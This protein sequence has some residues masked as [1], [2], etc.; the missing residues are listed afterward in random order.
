MAAQLSDLR[1]QSQQVTKRDKPRTIFELLDDPRVKQGLA[2]VAGRLLSPDRVMKL[3]TNAIYR[4]PKLALCE[5]KTVL[6]CLMASVSLGLEPNTPQGHAYLIPY[7]RRAQISG[8][9]QDVY[10][11]QFQV[12]YRGLI[13]LGYRSSKIRTIEAEAIHA[14]DH[15]KHMKGSKNFLE[16]EIALV[17]R[18]DLV[19]AYCHSHLTDDMEMATVMPLDRILSVRDRSET[20]VAL[21]SRLEEAKRAIETK[22]GDA[23]LQ[24]ELEK[25]Q[26]TF[27]E[28]PWVLRI[29][30]MASKTVVKRHVTAKLP[31]DPG[32]YLRAA[33]ELD[34][35][36]ER[37]VIDL[38]I[39]ADPDAASA[40][41]ADGAIPHEAIHEDNGAD[42]ADNNENH[43]AGEASP[44]TGSGADGS[45]ED[46]R[47]PSEGSANTSASESSTSTP[48]AERQRPRIME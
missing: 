7:R 39:L 35:A 15:F 23:K 2:T 12:G 29:D 36:A 45:S 44:A 25:A 3:V 40:V 5:P 33:I 6:G 38:S 26:R 11:C 24:K 13:V 17:N 31:L 48:R 10:D 9:W 34:N 42:P 41:I 32:D 16:H 28:T 37:G 21:R 43:A 30:E 46:P 1:A 47:P 14:N 27:D 4:T 20:F 8:V 19:G 18:G 22:P